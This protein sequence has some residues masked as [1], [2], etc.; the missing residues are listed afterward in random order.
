MPTGCQDVLIN[1][2]PDDGGVF[3]HEEEYSN[4]EYDGLVIGS[5][6]RLEIIDTVSGRVL[7]T[8]CDFIDFYFADSL[9]RVNAKSISLYG[10]VTKD[11]DTPAQVRVFSRTCCQCAVEFIESNVEGGNIVTIDLG[12][13]NVYQIYNDFDTGSVGIASIEF[14]ICG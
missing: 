13:D 6:G 5:C 4:L 10:V 11:T 9:G 2:A 1:F 7:T 8:D 12:V 14:E 3:Y